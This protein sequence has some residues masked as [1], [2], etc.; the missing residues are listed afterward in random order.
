MMYQWTDETHRAVCVIDD[1]VPLEDQVP[2][3]I[4]DRDLDWAQL[5]FDQVQP[6]QVE[7]YLLL[8][9]VRKTRDRL[10]QE[11]DWTQLSDAPVERDAWARYR[12]ALRDVPQQ[13]GFPAEVV[14]PEVG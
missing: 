4:T 9:R 1:S 10:L 13:K 7:D 8:Q 6:A 12:Q 3:I 11:S 5:P 2:C 14:W